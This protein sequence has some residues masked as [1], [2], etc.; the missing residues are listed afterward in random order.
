M[1]E[2]VLQAICQLESL[3]VAESILYM[4]I[5][6]QL[7]HSQDLTTQVES[8]AKSTLFSFLCCQCFHWF[9]IEVVVQVKEIE[10]LPVDQ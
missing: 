6:D 4:R 3:D 2:N 7:D 10:V 9:Q 5:D 8:I 1:R